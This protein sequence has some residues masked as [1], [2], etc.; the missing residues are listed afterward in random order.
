MDMTPEQCRAARGWLGW[1]REKLAEQARIGRNTVARYE[2]MKE[3][4]D[5]TRLAITICFE[6]LGFEFPDD[7]TVRRAPPED[8][9]RICS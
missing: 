9:Q 2:E 7:T 6:R 4:N 3:V 8:G 1:S 5:S